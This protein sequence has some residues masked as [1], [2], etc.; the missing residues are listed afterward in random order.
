M[1]ELTKEEQKEISQ[2]ACNALALSIKD[3]SEK[4]PQR[5]AASLIL[6]KMMEVICNSVWE[7]FDP[8]DAL[9]IMHSAMEEGLHKSWKKTEPI[10]VK[11]D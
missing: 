1:K 2:E 7:K 3:L 4:Y 8:R 10:P 9:L 11:K 6:G 5:V